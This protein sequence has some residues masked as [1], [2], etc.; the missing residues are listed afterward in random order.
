MRIAL[1]DLALA[2]SHSHSPTVGTYSDR[3][4]TRE[5]DSDHRALMI[6]VAVCALVPAVFWCGVAWC[7]GYALGSVPSAWTLVILGAII[8]AFLTV[9]AS[10]I[11]GG[12][13]S[14]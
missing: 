12:P 2:H 3:A 4:P 14:D 9:V 1:M 11:M 13:R 5:S 8:A 10:S 7:V 6:G